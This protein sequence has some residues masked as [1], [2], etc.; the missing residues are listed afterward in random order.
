MLLLMSAAP[1]NLYG[2]VANDSVNPGDKFCE[3]KIVPSVSDSSEEG[4][5]PV[6]KLYVWIEAEAKNTSNLLRVGK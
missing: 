6:K 2:K 5:K 1:G 4:L 3:G